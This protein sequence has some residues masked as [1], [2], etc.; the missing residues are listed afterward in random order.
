MSAK[1]GDV[2]TKVAIRVVFDP[3][4]ER[5]II[6]SH[7]ERLP[8]E[9]RQA[10]ITY[11]VKAA[12]PLPEVYRELRN[13]RFTTTLEDLVSA[14]QGEVESLGGE[15]RDWHGNLPEGINSSDKA[16][17][18]D[19]AASTLE[20]INFPEVPDALGQIKVMHLPA[21]EQDSRP[22]R[23]TEVV[24]MLDDAIDSLNAKA[25][26]LR[27]AIEDTK[28]AEAEALEAGP[29]APA[30]EAASADL[31]KEE[32]SDPQEMIEEIEPLVSELENVKGELENVAYPSMM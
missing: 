15:L 28:K 16:S 32:E 25:N 11:R 5:V 14:A 27:Q 31:N 23:S 24:S 2:L 10:P 1:P 17:E 7:L 12:L 18:I 30:P 8:R 4:F 6:G 26:D 29:T 3:Y 20:S 21:L 22:K 19:E 9:N 13:Q